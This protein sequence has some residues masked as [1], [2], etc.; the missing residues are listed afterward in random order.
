[1]I[2]LFHD[3]RDEQVVIFGGGSVAARKAARFGTEAT[4]IVA[5]A[6]FHERF[7]ERSCRQIRTEIREPLVESLVADAFLVIPA[8]DDEGLNR[9]VEGLAREAGSL[10]NPVDRRGNTVTPSTV[11]GSN[12][13]IAISTQGRSPAVSKYLRRRLESEIGRADGMVEVQSRLR[14][15]LSDRPESERR[16]RLWRVLEDDQIWEAIEAGALDRAETLAREYL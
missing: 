15:A 10:V 5:A 9:R 4:V 11:E 6:T 14:T 7:E 8:T 3:L 2:P 12:I 1:M 13:T 16:D